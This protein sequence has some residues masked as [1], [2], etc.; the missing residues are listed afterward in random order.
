VRWKA[1]PY[2]RE[3]HGS[4]HPDTA[5]LTIHFVANHASGVE[6]AD[7]CFL[8]LRPRGV[9][10][11]EGGQASDRSDAADAV[12]LE[13]SLLHLDLDFGCIDSRTAPAMQRSRARRRDG[14]RRPLRAPDSAVGWLPLAESTQASR[15][16][17]P[18]KVGE[19]FSRFMRIRSSSA[20]LRA[21]TPCPGPS[22][23][24]KRRCRVRR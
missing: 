18:R 15:S 5:P 21:C 9:A 22:R 10:A 17:L 2:R 16:A 4:S 14:A 20:L 6:P 3:A 12:P 7:A 13:A 1:P 24:S 8:R 23:T 11:P 19:L